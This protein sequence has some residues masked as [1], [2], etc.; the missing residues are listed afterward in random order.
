M[1][2]IQGFSKLSKVEKIKWLSELDQL[3]N[4]PVDSL[5]RQYWNADQELQQIHDEFRNTI[6]NFY[7]PYAI[8]PNFLMTIPYAI[9]MA[10]EESSVVAAAAMP[11]SI[12]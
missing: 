7:L 2:P 8:A 5:L 9:P 1:A 10:I 4:T 6:S 11:R 12:G 3:Q